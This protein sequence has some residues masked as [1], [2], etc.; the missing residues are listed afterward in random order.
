[1][2]AGWAGDGPGGRG[3]RGRGWPRAG[4]GL[5]PF[6]KKEGTQKRVSYSFVNKMMYFVAPRKL[7][8]RM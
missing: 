8:K 1:M 4:A 3:K 7:G 6:G 2:L 5:G